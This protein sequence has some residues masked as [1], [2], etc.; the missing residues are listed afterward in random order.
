MYKLFLIFLFSIMV[1]SCGSLPADVTIQ[2][3]IN[4][5]YNYNSI[6]LFYS[7]YPMYFY[8]NTYLDPYG[9]E[10]YMHMHPYFKRYR[11]ECIRR[12]P[13]HVPTPGHQATTTKR[14]NQ[15]T[16]TR[17]PSTTTRTTQ[18][19]TR[20]VRPTTTRTVRPSTTNRSTRTQTRT[21]TTRSTTRRNTS[22]RK[23]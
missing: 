6:H 3:Q 7:Q 4:Q 18:P 15:S 2:Y 1:Y 12:V 10:R 17:R 8:H 9:V 19:T 5:P 14:Y 21:H 22:V 23:Q 16:Q 20:T 11:R 13:V